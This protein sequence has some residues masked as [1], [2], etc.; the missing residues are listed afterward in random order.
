M[1]DRLYKLVALIHLSP[2]V[3]ATTGAAVTPTRAPRKKRVPAVE[4]ED[5]VTKEEQMR[6]YR[7]AETCVCGPEDDPTKHQQILAPVRGDGFREGR[8]C[9]VKESSKHHPKL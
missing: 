7:W 1:Y 3:T 6:A 9:L 8:E 5:G 2:I 4:L